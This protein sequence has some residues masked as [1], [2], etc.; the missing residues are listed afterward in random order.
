MSRSC[1][2]YAGTSHAR[3]SGA[4]FSTKT[5]PAASC[6]PRS[7]SAGRAFS[8][9]SRRTSCTWSSSTPTRMV[10]LPRFRKPPLVL[11]RV[12]PVLG[13]HQRVDDV[14]GVL[15]LND[16]EDQLHSQSG[17]AVKLAER[18]PASATELGLAA[19]KIAPRRWRPHAAHARGGAAA[20]T[21]RP[22]PPAGPETPVGLG[23][24]RRSRLRRG[25]GAAGRRE[26]QSATMP[27]R[28]SRSPS[29]S[30]STKGALPL[31]RACGVAQLA[32]Q[33]ERLV[34]GLHDVA[35][36]QADPGQQLFEL[37]ATAPG[38]GDARE[39][40]REA[41]RQAQAVLGLGAQHLVLDPLD[42]LTHV[43]DAVGRAGSG[44]RTPCRGRSRTS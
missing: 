6:G 5:L 37:G 13:L 25:A 32:H 42:P 1:S 28:I 34:E 11:I 15:I 36:G 7:P 3:R 33:V 12:E 24:L 8:R 20:Q 27:R 29:S 10:A 35:L 44:C 21:A 43:P 4:T 26:Q 30:I 14:A 19:P 17:P 18:P 16:R 39:G 40:E 22:S 2:W 41:G 31:E 23:P 9:M 38:V